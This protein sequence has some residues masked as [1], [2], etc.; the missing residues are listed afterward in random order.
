MKYK[1][2]K[3]SDLYFNL[4]ALEV[5][6]KAANYLAYDVVKEFGAE[7]F[8]LNPHSF[9]GG[10]GGIVF[11]RKPEGWKRVGKDWQDLYYPKASNK[12][13]LEKI[14]GLPLVTE[15]EYNDITGFVGMQTISSG[16]GFY[17]IGSPGIYFGDEEILLDV[18]S[19]CTFTPKEGMIEILE[20]EYLKLKGK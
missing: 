4:R 3:E 6:I 7:K 11:D 10:I 16:Q 2:S 1:I 8:A 9:A 12:M 18:N 17:L 5:K 14:K 15:K 20:S 19:Q 13:D